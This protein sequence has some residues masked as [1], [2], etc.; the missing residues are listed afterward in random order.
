MFLAH[1]VNMLHVRI[2]V[3]VMNLYLALQH[4]VVHR[5]PNFPMQQRSRGGHL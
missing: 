5:Q 3:S 1:L 4:L 2:V